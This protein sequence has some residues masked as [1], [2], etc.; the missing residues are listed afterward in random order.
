MRNC[1]L[2]LLLLLSL[3]VPAQDT[4]RKERVEIERLINKGGTYF[5]E[6]QYD[7]AL[8]ASKQALVR[9]FKLDDD[10][11]IAHSYNAIGVIYDEFSESDY[12]IE[13]YNKAL[14]HANKIE[15]DSLKD[16][17]Y[18]NLGSVYYFSHKDVRKGIEYYKK[19]LVFA[20]KINDSSQ[21]SYTQM[22]I[23]SAYFS[24]EEYELGR[25]FLEQA[26]SYVRQK[27]EQEARMTLSM[28]DAMY[29]SHVGHSTEAEH[30][31]AKA[32]VIAKREKMSAFEANIY[33]NLV[34]HHRKL[35]Q[36]AKANLY[37]SKLDSLKKVLYP[38]DERANLDET[39]REI[40]LDA[41]RIQL[42][43]IEA[44]ND[45]QHRKIRETRL[46]TLLF[47]V[48]LLFVIVYTVT[49]Y[50]NNKNRTR[51]NAELTTAN[52]ELR[53]AK[54]AAEEVSQLKTQFVSNI[55]HELRTPLYGVIGL[56]DMFLEKHK[57]LLDDEEVNSLK[58]SARYLLALVNDV[59]QLNKMED[60][61]IALADAPFSVRRQLETITN[62]LQ[63]IA[64]RNG[65]RLESVIDPSI[66]SQ[67]IGDELRLSQILIN[68][69]SNALKFTTNGNV[70]VSADR[71]RGDNNTCTVRFTVS[72][73][74]VGIAEKDQYRIFERFVQVDRKGSDYQG[75]GLGLAIVKRLLELFGSD[76]DLHSEEGIGTTIRFDI[77]FRVA[78]TNETQTPDG[79]SADVGSLRVLVV[80]DNKIN[81][82]V[83]QNILQRNGHQCDLIDNGRAAIEKV[84]NAAYD[85][86]LM[87]INMPDLDGY[88]TATAIR[89]K[90]I[91]IPILALTAFDRNEVTDK[92]QA[93]GI[94]AVIVKP[95]EP[96][97]FL[98]QI[99]SMTTKK[100]VN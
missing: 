61:R 12:A 38:E 32:L 23:A 75:T 16:W 59:L 42:A 8:D 2:V 4:D 13:F 15:N 25:R 14:Q 67:L 100:P 27:G 88:E 46:L 11:L 72:D 76:I 31:F 90:G 30:Q 36:V 52:Q 99:A 41:Y 7:K 35:G 39:A 34:N 86:I 6:A 69:M 48:V 63:F 92:A 81:Q 21:I 83:T 93:A 53:K 96:T 58:F 51:L 77:T 84:T 40:E 95:F 57:E 33:E 66:P 55:S 74:G 68:L 1:C 64:D 50:K 43:K 22:N 87:D 17:L 45:L 18:S 98:T 49:L 37:Q 85:V 94:D 19:S 47:G 97:D 5:R 82:I 91:Q 70:K 3:S 71:L 24:I 54:E 89:R 20:R 26:R 28:L 10:Y 44:D 62:S 78:A 29:N 60:R 79:L 56:T 65:N 9:S 73:N 80:E